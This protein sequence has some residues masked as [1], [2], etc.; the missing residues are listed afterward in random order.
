MY[1]GKLKEIVK[2]IY[3]TSSYT[4]HKP[5]GSEDATLTFR[6]VDGGRKGFVWTMNGHTV[7]RN[8]QPHYFKKYG[9][10]RNSLYNELGHACLQESREQIPV[11]PVIRA[12]RTD[13][14]RKRQFEHFIEE[15]ELWDKTAGEIYVVMER[16]Y[17]KLFQIYEPLPVA[18]LES[19]LL[20]I[21]KKGR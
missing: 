4:F 17:P 1:R 19:D 3:R 13:V 16:Q 21:K 9:L 20:G 6:V 12:T 2:S 7:N 18:Q 15:N 14:I 11:T 10:D 8:R 5:D